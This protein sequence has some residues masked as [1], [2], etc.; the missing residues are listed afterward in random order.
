ML[1]SLLKMLICHLLGDF[2]LQPRSWT[3]KRRHHIRYLGYHLAVHAT[4]LLVFFATSLAENWQ[5]IVAILAAHLAIDS[6]KIGWE[7]RFKGHRI[8]VFSIDQLLHLLSIGAVFFFNHPDLWHD[9]REQWVMDRIWAILIAL[10]IIL[11]VIPIIIRIF[12]SRWEREK[13]FSLRESGSLLDA[14][15]IIG[16]IERLLILVFVLLDFM[17]GVGF[18]LAAKSIFRF[19]DLS[20]AK[21][22][23]F[24]E[25]V[26]IGTLLSFGMG[27][28]VALALQQTLL[29]F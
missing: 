20:S 19:G 11:F 21:D 26:L 23:K 25:Y 6:L 12:F 16:V 28:L 5:N 9:W 13:E 24:T 8:W 18:L 22:T 29:I 27:L 4:L 15:T 3:I 7:H 10:T 14:G 2:V 1:S 17:E